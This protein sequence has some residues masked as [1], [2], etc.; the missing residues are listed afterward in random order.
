MSTPVDFHL[1]TRR[2]GAPA[3]LTV[4]A[5][6]LREAVSAVGGASV[7][8]AAEPGAALPFDAGEVL[9]EPAAL[10]FDA[11]GARCFHG[12]VTAARVE[13]R[14]GVASCALELA[15]R[16]WRA[17]RSRRSRAFLELSVH[18]IVRRVL[19]ENGLGDDDFAW[20]CASPIPPRPYAV[21]Y[22]ESD[23]DFLQRTLEREGVFYYVDHAGGRDRVVFGDHNNA[24]APLDEAGAAVGFAPHGGGLDGFSG[25]REWARVARLQ[26]RAVAVRDYR[27]HAPRVVM[28][29]RLAPV[30]DDRWTVAESGLQ[31]HY[32]DHVASDEDAAR[33]ARLRAELLR[34][35]ADRYEGV[36]QV[37]AVRA[38]A[39]FALHNHPEA[40]FER[41]YVVLRAT[42]RYVLDRGLGSSANKGAPR[43]DNLVE[44]LPREVPFR[45]ER[46][47]PRPVMPPWIPAVVADVDARQRKEAEVTSPLDELGR[48]RVVFPFDTAVVGGGATSCPVPLAPSFAGEGFGEHTPLHRGT[49]VLVGH[50]HG[51]PDRPVIVAALMPSVVKHPTSRGERLTRG[52]VREDYD[53]HAPAWKAQPRRKRVTTTSDRI[54]DAVAFAGRAIEKDRENRTAGPLRAAPN[55]DRTKKE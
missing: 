25:A 14:E 43:Y 27:P 39:A 42:H 36:T 40:S 31:S 15:P 7:T 46:A 38:G 3:G 50:V 10:A 23:L 52:G 22:E 41:E 5:V 18:D 48:Y 17:S 44:A 6:E 1:E 19:A 2:W 21:Q 55:A 51:D 34:C 4:V 45:P 47:T 13:V 30:M 32:G 20:R 12:I 33:A 9:G 11:A 24:F 53:D 8:L 54:D 49:H 35:G 37:S 28:N 26:P 16:L 29:T